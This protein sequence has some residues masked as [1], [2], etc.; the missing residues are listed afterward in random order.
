MIILKKSTIV[1][2]IILSVFFIHCNNEHKCELAGKK[3]KKYTDIDPDLSVG[4]V[5]SNHDYG[6]FAGIKNRNRDLWYVF[7]RH[8]E[9][10]G[11]EDQISTILDTLI[12]EYS[13]YDDTLVLEFMD[14]R[15][16]NYNYNVVAIYDR[17]SRSPVRTIA[18]AW[19]ADTEKKRFVELDPD[20]VTCMSEYELYGDEP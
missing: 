4:N 3:Y 14:C 1:F 20:S 18:K 15:Y 11:T 17:Y 8:T 9:N 13:K 12:I 16:K 6:V 19:A 7:F 2:L 10:F 5:V